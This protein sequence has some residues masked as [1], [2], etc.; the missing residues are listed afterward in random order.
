MHVYDPKY[1]KAPTAK[2]DAPAAP[3]SAYLKMCPRLGIERTVVVQP[4]TYGKD[5][6]C[7]LEAVAAMGQMRAVSLWLIRT[8]PILNLIG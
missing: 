6:R 1:P 5:N 2:I 8:S 4:S 7:T 3:V